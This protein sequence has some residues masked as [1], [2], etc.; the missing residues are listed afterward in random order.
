M[1]VK[2]SNLADE[3]E[4]AW[5]GSWKTSKQMVEFN[6][7]VRFKIISVSNFYFALPGSSLFTQTW[8]NMGWFHVIYK[9]LINDWTC[10]KAF[11]NG[12]RIITWIFRSYLETKK[13]PQPIST[14]CSILV[15]SIDRR[16]SNGNIKKSWEEVII[17]SSD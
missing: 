12:V 4:E 16:D 5:T 17:F 10:G 6:E 9:L 1:Y 11:S 7:F 15:V 2:N 3:S 8:N 14:L 13:S